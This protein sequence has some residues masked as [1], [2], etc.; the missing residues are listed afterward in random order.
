[1]NA[2]WAIDMLQ[3][4]LSYE[5]YL[6]VDT[7]RYIFSV[8]EL[9]LWNRI[10]PVF[11]VTLFVQLWKVSFSGDLGIC[12]LVAIVIIWVGHL[13]SYVICIMSVY[14]NNV[15]GLIFGVWFH[16]PNS[17]NRSENKLHSSTPRNIHSILLNVLGTVTQDNVR[18]KNWEKPF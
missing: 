15:E 5:N 2:T 3:V 14:S 6:P 8:N 16:Q 7:P 4:G 18:T 10:R 13:S 11:D 17:D 1:M 9:T 12:S